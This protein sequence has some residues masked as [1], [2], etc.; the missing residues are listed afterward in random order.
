MLFHHNLLV[1]YDK[2]FIHYRYN[3][4]NEIFR[5]PLDPDQ[6]KQVRKEY[7][8]IIRQWIAD[9]NQSNTSDRQL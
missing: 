7:L 9:A 5:N 6:V 1:V 4:P 8:S 3:G 2:P